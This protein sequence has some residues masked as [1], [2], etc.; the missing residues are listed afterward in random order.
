MRDEEGRNR[1][2]KR[3]RGRECLFVATFPTC[4]ENE[5]EQRDQ[6]N[7]REIGGKLTVRMNDH[8]LHFINCNVT[9]PLIAFSLVTELPAY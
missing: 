3:G 4:N 5:T 7:R 2:K 6:R 8:D 9:L 1:S